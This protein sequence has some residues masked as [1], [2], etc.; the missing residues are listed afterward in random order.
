M[1]D[2]RRFLATLP[3]V[4]V[5][6]LMSSEPRPRRGRGLRILMLGGTRY[7]G[8]HLVR[9]ALERGH[10]VTLFNRGITNPHL[11]PGLEKLRGNRYPD[12]GDGLA[13]LETGRRWDVVLD[14]WQEA[15]GC[16]DLTTRLL[17]GR[18]ERYLYI[19]SIATF[20]DYREIG[21]TEAGPLLDATE[22]IRSFEHPGPGYS[23]RKRAGEQAVERL[24][25]QGTILR[26]T[27]I[28]GFSESPDAATHA[29]DTTA[30]FQ[31]IDVKDVARFA[32]HAVEN[33]YGGTY[34]VVGPER[35]L[36]LRDYVEAWHAATG[37]RSDVAWATRSFL[38]EH[39]VAPFEDIRNWIPGDVPEPGFYRMSGLRARSRG[40]TCRPL[41]ATIRDAIASTGEPGAL[42]PPEVGMSLARER[43]LVR[44]WR[45][46]SNG[47]RP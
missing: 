7:L 31:L 6:P 29:D 41:L 8:P 20:R 38:R 12:R 19:S 4:G 47:A 3:L 22:H 10:Q 23:L 18:P 17:A 15:A 2:R 46:A 26:C 44:L 43:E 36:L 1:I 14:T 45:A 16:V 40:L 11:F 34:D 33:G 28:Q 5:A 24:G 13:A 27:S 25:G 21:M 32:I 30:F 39:D 37:R 35:P 42:E 9:T